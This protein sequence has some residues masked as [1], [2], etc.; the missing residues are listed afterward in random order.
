MLSGSLGHSIPPSVL[1][2]VS[3][4]L[5]AELQKDIRVAKLSDLVTAYSCLCV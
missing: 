5:P 4:L 1:S 3:E 2:V